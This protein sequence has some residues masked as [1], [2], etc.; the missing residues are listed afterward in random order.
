MRKKR[1]HEDFIKLVNDMVGYNKYEFLTKYIT[2]EDRVTIKCKDDNYIWS[3]TAQAFLNS[4]CK[5]PKCSKKVMN[6][7]TEYFKNELKE[8]YGDKYICLGEYVNAKTKILL[9]HNTPY[10]QHEFMKTPDGMLNKKNGC[11]KCGNR[12]GSDKLF[13]SHEEF[14][15]RTSKLFNNEFEILSQYKGGKEKVTVRHIPCGRIYDRQA[16]DILQGKGCKFCGFGTTKDTQWFKEKV[17]EMYQEEY[18]VLGEYISTDTT[19]L[20]RHNKCGKEYSIRPIDF[21]R[22]TRC[23]CES[24]SKGEKIIEIFLRFNKIKFKQQY[25]YEDCKNKA[26]LPFDCAVKDNNGQVIFLIEFDGIQHYEPIYGEEQFVDTKYN[27][28]TKNSYCEDN[29]IPLVRIPFWD[30]D[31]INN[32]LID[33]FKNININTNMPTEGLNIWEEGNQFKLIKLLK[34]LPNGIYPKSYVI[35]QL[36]STTV[37]SSLANILRIDCVK[38]VCN[39]LNIQYN[40]KT[41]TILNNYTNYYKYN[42][43]IEIIK[44]YRITKSINMFADLYNNMSKIIDKCYKKDIF[45]SMNCF[46]GLDKQS[47]EYKFIENF[48]E[49]NNLYF[50]HNYICKE[51]IKNRKDLI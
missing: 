5:C 45:C 43:L 20:M 21:I 34:E 6:K 24:T 49:E 10:C 3:P 17:Y 32:I 27:D 7:D 36:N 9:K 14:C 11:P 12:K 4:K 33:Y 46:H 44:T 13:I 42:N 31:K 22:G 39:K 29:N 41:I 38:E 26:R 2:C 25:T 15:D 40:N 28:A 51:Q 19:I 37:I 16:G 30:M 18:T 35:E 8:L 48:M 1:T 50:E 47:Y 23:K